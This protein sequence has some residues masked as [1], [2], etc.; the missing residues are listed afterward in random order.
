MLWVGLDPQDRSRG[1]ADIIELAET[2][3]E[4][5]RDLLPTAET[6]T[7]LS[8]GEAEATGRRPVELDGLGDRLAHLE[9][10]D[11]TRR[12]G[13]GPRPRTDASQGDT[14]TAGTQTAGPP[15]GGP[16]VGAEV[17]ARGWGS[18]RPRPGEGLRGAGALR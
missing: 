15:E 7:A 1:T 6:Y 5:A 14:S 18:T 2:L 3:G 9:T 16:A 12:A 13:D 4:L 11:R 10:T 17:A 8:L